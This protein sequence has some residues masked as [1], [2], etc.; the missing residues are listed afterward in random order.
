MNHEPLDHFHQAFAALAK[1]LPGAEPPWLR[2][3]RR[4]AF[5]CF[6]TLGVPTP[7]HEDWKYTNVAALGKRA[8]HFSPQRL[9]EAKAARLVEELTFAG[10]EHRLVFLN[11]CYAPKLSRVNQLPHG[12]FVGSLSR[13]LRE[14]P[15]RLEAMFSTQEWH[16]GLA[17]LNT[18][19]L[20][21]G[22][23]VALP[24]DTKLDDPLHMV[25]LANEADLAVQPFNVVLAGARSSCAIVEQ[26]AGLNDN[27][28]LTNTITRIVADDYADVQH[29]RLQQEGN[30]AFH[31]AR[32]DVEQR[33]SSHFTSHAFAFGSALSRTGIAANLS[34]CEADVT[35][36]GLY[37]AG[38]RQHVD[39]HTCIDHAQPHGTSREYYRGVLA[40]AARGVFNGRV[41]VRPDAQQ[42]DAH[43]ANHNL[44]LS[45]DAEIDTKPQLEIFADDV[46]CTHGATVGQLDE[47]QLFYLRSRGVDETTARALLTYAFARDIVE[48]VRIDALRGRLENL[49]LARMPEAGRAK[50]LIW[51]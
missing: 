5:E 26:F 36:N 7:R 41:I 10:R 14:M 50:D 45:R 9:D 6:G 18:A 40:G 51:T 27:L 42:T 49:L 12:A 2:V 19:F 8:W 29:Y 34:A 11:G 32:I 33:Q 22:F 16:D 21:D 43:Q 37:F 3:A 47:S 39:H 24:P 13:A 30:R 4:R 35:L 44:L 31:I 38:G 17:A 28:Y 23:V 46:R 15:D 25:F 20:C 48:R 1:T